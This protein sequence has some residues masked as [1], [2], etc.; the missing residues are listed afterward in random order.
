MIVI[1]SVSNIA[2]RTSPEIA[3]E[4]RDGCLA[5]SHLIG[6]IATIKF[7]P[8]IGPVG[9]TVWT[10]SYRFSLR[11]IESCNPPKSI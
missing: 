8:T 4:Q 11:R 10:D 9:F 2:K 5:E 3:L 7:I 6:L 1:M